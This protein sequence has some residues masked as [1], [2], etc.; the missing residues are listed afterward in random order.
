MALVWAVFGSQGR[1]TGMLI[2]LTGQL[3]VLALHGNHLLI[4]RGLFLAFLSFSV[5]SRFSPPETEHSL[6]IQNI[7]QPCRASLNLRLSPLSRYVPR[8]SLAFGHFTWPPSYHSFPI[9][10]SGATPVTPWLNL[11]QPTRFIYPSALRC[12]KHVYRQ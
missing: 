1:S 7:Y 6:Y 9:V 12:I 3:Q 4:S 2:G 5:L 8:A 11:R 10:S